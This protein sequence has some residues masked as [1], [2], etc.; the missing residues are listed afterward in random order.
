MRSFVIA[1][2][3]A[4][5]ALVLAG[6]APARDRP[7]PLVVPRSGAARRASEAVASA[8]RGETPPGV[9]IERL[10]DHRDIG[11]TGVSTEKLRVSIERPL[12]IT[13][14]HVFVIHAD[15]DTIQGHGPTLVFYKPTSTIVE[16]HGRKLTNPMRFSRRPD[17]GIELVAYATGPI[18]NVYR[19]S[20]E[21]GSVEAELTAGGKTLPGSEQRY[22]VPSGLAPSLELF[23]ALTRRQLPS[24]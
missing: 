24:R 9:T 15:N 16:S 5:H 7:R 14:N 12:T 6:T 11:R 3:V 4:S 2:L 17:G 19:Y 10:G 1:A 18:Q 22:S 20:P 23:Y 13:Q 21:T 8:L